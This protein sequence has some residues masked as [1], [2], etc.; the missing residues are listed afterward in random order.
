MCRG[1]PHAQAASYVISKT[2]D[3]L[4]NL[5][6]LHNAGKFNG[7]FSARAL[8]SVRIVSYHWGLLYK[9][10]LTSIGVLFI[11]FS[12]FYQCGVVSPFIY[13]HAMCIF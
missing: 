6:C 13:C 2:F 10:L 1:H 11:Q 8:Q 12:D 5:D 4:D 9:T 7:S 3:C